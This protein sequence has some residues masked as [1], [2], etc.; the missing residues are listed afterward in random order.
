MALSFEPLTQETWNDFETFLGAYEG[1]KGCWCMHWRMSFA[2]WKKQ[3]GEGNRRAMQA[4][5]DSGEVPGILA[6]E[7]GY[8]VAWCGCGPREWY[9]RLNKSPVTKPV[10]ERQVLT[11]NCF[12]VDRSARGKNIQLALLH[13]VSRFA[14]R[15]GYEV[16]EGYPVEPQGRRLDASTSLVGLAR[17]FEEAGFSEVA[18]RKANRPVMR[19]D[20]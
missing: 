13:E 16:V 15:Q 6:Y 11:V 20:I 4:C 10:D 1:C 2:D 8:P 19:K 7:D 18:R 14:K 9:P 12:F 5:V 3:Q 17:A